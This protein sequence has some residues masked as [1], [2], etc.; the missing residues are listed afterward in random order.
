MRRSLRE[1]IRYLLESTQDE[2]CP[3]CMTSKPF[4]QTE[5][6]KDTDK[7]HSYD[8]IECLHCGFKW[9]SAFRIILS[10]IVLEIKE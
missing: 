5:V 8:L 1:S 6:I 9:Q 7:T 2:V 3:S 4:K 10:P